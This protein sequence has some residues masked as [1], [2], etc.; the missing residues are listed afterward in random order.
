MLFTRVIISHTYI[1]LGARHSYIARYKHF[2]HRHAYLFP[3]LVWVD[4][5]IYIA[6]TKY[7]HVCIISAVFVYIKFSLL[8]DYCIHIHNNSGNEFRLNKI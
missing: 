5:Y 7:Q 1:I 8:L 6:V 4:L 2:L 3:K